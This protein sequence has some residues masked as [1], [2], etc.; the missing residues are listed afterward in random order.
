MCS[1]F[2]NNRDLIC[3]NC[4]SWKCPSCINESHSTAGYVPSKEYKQH[5]LSHSPFSR[6]EF[7]YSEEDK[8][9]GGQC[10]VPMDE[11]AKSCRDS[12]LFWTVGQVIFFKRRRTGIAEKGI[13]VSVNESIEQKPALRVR[14]FIRDYWHEKFDE[15]IPITDIYRD[16]D[17]VPRQRHH[18]DISTESSP[19]MKHEVNVVKIES[20]S[21]SDSDADEYLDNFA[22]HSNSKNL[23]SGFFNTLS[24]DLFESSDSSSSEESNS[25]TDDSPGTT[26][27]KKV[28]VRERN[29]YRDESGSVMS[30]NIF[31]MELEEIYERTPIL[32]ASG[33]PADVLYLEDPQIE[34]VADIAHIDECI[35][36]GILNSIYFEGLKYNNSLNSDERRPSRSSIIA[37]PKPLMISVEELRDLIQ[38]C[39]VTTS[40]VKRLLPFRSDPFPFDKIASWIRN[41]LQ[42]RK[43]LLPLTPTG[44]NNQYNWESSSPRSLTP[45]AAP[46]TFQSSVPLFFRQ[47]DSF[48]QV[49]FHEIRKL[50]LSLPL[51]FSW[52]QFLLELAYHDFGGRVLLEKGQGI[53]GAIVVGNIRTMYGSMNDNFIDRHVVQ[54]TRLG[55]NDRF[56]DIG[57]GIGQV[58][59]AGSI[60][61]FVDHA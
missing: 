3:P 60:L 18:Q 44:N 7:V 46:L 4:L 24:Y 53:A 33:R 54:R 31:Q 22:S 25:T 45:D 12:K 13:V 20:I 39:P 15:I 43:R 37:H 10:I 40:S 61:V 48:R 1:T 29:K 5:I 28:K 38:Y 35:Q 16:I 17:D 9:H 19:S 23:K 56:L 21:D 34:L 27:S 57:S 8:M 30:L 14:Y 11:Y 52:F 51:E 59:V 42:S 2:G 32:P 49:S 50:N 41:Y 47:W 26:Q 36:G 6:P 58:R 55:I